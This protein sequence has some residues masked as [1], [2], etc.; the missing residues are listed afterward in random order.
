MSLCLVKPLPMGFT[1]RNF[2]PY[3]VEYILVK[4]LAIFL[5]QMENTLNMKI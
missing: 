5:M 2:L 1:S 3:E 4:H